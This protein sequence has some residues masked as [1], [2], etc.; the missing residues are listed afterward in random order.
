M[1]FRDCLSRIS[2]AEGYVRACACIPGVAVARFARF[3][4]VC[5]LSVRKSHSASTRMA[6]GAHLEPLPLLLGLLLLLLLLRGDVT[7]R[8]VGRCARLFGFRELLPACLRVRYDTQSSRRCVAQDSNLGLAPVR[9]ARCRRKHIGSAR[10]D[11]MRITVEQCA[12]AARHPRAEALPPRS[13]SPC[14]TAS[15]RPRSAPCSRAASLP[16]P[17]R[18]LDPVLVYRVK[19]AVNSCVVITYCPWC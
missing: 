3:P 18:A 19:P 13:T 14:K 7:G 5:A 17:S 4:R 6:R 11:R 2:A 16:P 8:R 1:G 9:G 10:G 15:L 12:L